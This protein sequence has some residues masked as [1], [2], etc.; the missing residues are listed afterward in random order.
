MSELTVETIGI[1]T[2]E[3][4]PDNARVGDVEALAES[5]TRF[6]QV[7]PILVQKSTGFVV[8]GNHTREAAKSLGWE[9]IQA[10]LLEMDDE[11]A[12]AYLLADNR[13]SDRAKYDTAKLYD[14][15]E[16]L[17]DL[18]GT[19]F[20]LDYVES[21]GDALGAHVVAD[22]DTG[23]VVRQA[24]PEQTEK[25]KANAAAKAAAPQ[26][27]MR[28]IVML[29]TVSRAQ[30]FGEKVARLQKFYETRTVVDTVERAVDDAIAKLEADG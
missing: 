24:A 22:T 15:L 27:A 7:K 23:D 25:S 14:S 1:D 26:E 8:A 10:V 6:G 12:K 20:D 16:S 2:V 13:L 11:T 29:M 5:L 3:P 30:A 28:D 18:D 4:H 19:G 17:L 21:L 9:E